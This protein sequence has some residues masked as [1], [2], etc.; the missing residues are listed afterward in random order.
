V[1]VST[2]ICLNCSGKS[3]LKQDLNVGFQVFMI[4]V[5]QLVGF[6]W[7]SVPY[8]RCVFWHSTKTSERHLARG[9]EN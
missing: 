6:F 5:D 7:I 2:I 8:G 1:N 4:M 3:F 9:R